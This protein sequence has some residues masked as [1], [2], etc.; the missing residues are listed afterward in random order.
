MVNKLSNRGQST[1]AINKIFRSEVKRKKYIGKFGELI[2]D[3]CTC[4]DDGETIAKLF[5]HDGI[6]CGGMQVGAYAC[7][8]E[9]VAAVTY[10]FEITN[11]VNGDGIIVI[12]ATGSDGT[13]QD[14]TLPEPTLPE[15]A[16]V[17]LDN[18][19][20]VLNVP[21][22]T[23]TFSAVNDL[24]E[25]PAADVV[26]NINPLIT[27][28]TSSPHPTFVGG[29]DVNT[30]YDAGTNTWTISGLDT[31]ITSSSLSYNVNTNSLQVNITENGNTIVGNIVELPK[32]GFVGDLVDGNI[33]ANNQWGL[34]ARNLAINHSSSGVSNP[35]L[36]LNTPE[37]RNRD[38]SPSSVV[39]GLFDSA[40]HGS[41]GGLIGIRN[42]DGSFGN[43][44]RLLISGQEAFA[45]DFFNGSWI[46]YNTEDGNN[47]NIGAPKYNGHVVQITMNGAATSSMSVTNTGGSF[48]GNYR[49]VSNGAIN[50]IFVGGTTSM[51]LRGTEAVT[52]RGLGTTWIVTE[53]N[54]NLLHGQG[55]RELADG[56]IS[57]E[58]NLPF[59]PAV[60]PAFTTAPIIVTDTANGTFM[61]S[62]G[63]L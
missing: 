37:S 39:S 46:N 61:F 36:L 38:L 57:G 50:D 22:G 54:Y 40:I 5:M 51:W 9:P 59:N 55:W 6:T 1:V 32:D 34:S 17:H 47:F 52:L 42:S 10:E 16:G 35:T 18:T 63:K 28:L 21:A 29:G 62:G 49:D 31:D 56:T 3:M 14:I 24:D 30:S 33:P 48:I 25:S 41:V 53:S 58:G 44:S 8:P 20:P 2:A 15:T 45:T 26:L 60:F 19:T 23:V 43:F 7:S 11:P 12:T 27:A 13:V 4:N